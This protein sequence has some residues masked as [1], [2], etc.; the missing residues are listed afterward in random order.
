MR[1]ITLFM[2]MVLVAG[3]TAIAETTLLMK[4]KAMRLKR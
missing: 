1:K 2:A 4:M 3:S